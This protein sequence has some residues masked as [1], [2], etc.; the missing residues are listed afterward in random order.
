MHMTNHDYFDYRKNQKTRNEPHVGI[1]MVQVLASPV[2]IYGLIIQLIKT[3]SCYYITLPNYAYTSVILLIK[4]LAILHPGIIW[5]THTRGVDCKMYC[6]QWKWLWNQWIHALWN[7]NCSGC[8]FAKIG[9][10]IVCR[11]RRDLLLCAE[12]EGTC[13]CVQSEKGPVIVCR[14]RRD[15][16]LCAEWEGTCYCVQSEK[17]PVIVCRVRRDLLL[18]AE[19]EGTC[20]CVQSEKGLVIVCRALHK[21]LWYDEAAVK[22]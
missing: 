9:P 5:T 8:C 2:Y 16:L 19:G 4:L 22:G 6:T 14:V 12:W 10:V 13:Y 7:T 21:P 17:G 20:Y 3:P 1:K 11:V 15:L 18:C